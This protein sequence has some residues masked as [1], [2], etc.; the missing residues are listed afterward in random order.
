MENFEIRD[1]RNKSMFRVDDE[2]LNGY[3]RLCGTNATM[4]Y[5]CLCRHSDRHQES[6]PSVQLMA[7][8]LGISRDSV[9][10][11]IKTLVQWNIIQK[12]RKR[13]ENAQ[14]LNNTYVLL[15]KTVWKSKPSSTQLHGEPSSTQPESQVAVSDTKDTHIKKET[16]NEAEASVAR[17]DSFFGKP[18][19]TDGVPMTCDQFVL[20][21]RGSQYRH[22][23]IIGEHA[24]EK[25]L[26]YTTRGQW[27]EFG[28]RNLQAARKLAPYTDD[29][30]SD[31]MELMEKDFKSERN[32]RGFITKWGMETLLKYL[33]EI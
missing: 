21:C 31:A 18:K 5:L 29:Q 6:F 19:K 2:Y 30:L 24:D 1:H 7:N 4:V 26:D 22:I 28:N 11:G 14:W 20:M 17:S 12:N 33:D 16:H 25:Q 23:R 8:K 10:R 3:S 15:D 13:K 9:M 27:R 32:P